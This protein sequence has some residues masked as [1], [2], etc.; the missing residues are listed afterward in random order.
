MERGR[1]VK[2]FLIIV[3]LVIGIVVGMIG[4]SRAVRKYLK[5]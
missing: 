2:I 3:I 1:V 5:V 4:S